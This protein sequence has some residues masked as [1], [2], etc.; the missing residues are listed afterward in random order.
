MCHYLSATLA[1]LSAA[2]CGG[3]V[4]R[5]LEAGEEQELHP[6]LRE[7]AFHPLPLLGAQH[8]PRTEWEPAGPAG[9]LHISFRVAAQPG[10]KSLPPGG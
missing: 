6:V 5:R 4:L 9:S 2:G 1:S 3:R 7:V 10:L 8:L